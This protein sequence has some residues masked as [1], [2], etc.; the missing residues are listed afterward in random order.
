MAIE[1]ARKKAKELGLDLVEVAPLAKPPV[2][3]LVRFQEFLAKQLKKTR[4]GSK[5]TNQ[6][7]KEIRL[8][9]FVD[10]HDLEIKLERIKEFLAL[11][12]RVQVTIVFFGRII[13]RKNLG[14]ILMQ[15]IIS[16][17]ENSARLESGPS[18]KGHRLTSVFGSRK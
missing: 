15:K 12:Y 7:L 10:D 3:R 9:P 4:G 11:G 2:T 18:F 1:E 13:T 8:K 14:E 17:L 5:R 16:Q 6:S